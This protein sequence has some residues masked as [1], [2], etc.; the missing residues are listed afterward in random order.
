MLGDDDVT[1]AIPE[2]LGPARP[3]EEGDPVLGA[4]G[5]ALG[6]REGGPER[7]GSGLGRQGV[8]GGIEAGSC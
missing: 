1:A 3:L 7:S 5:L 8:K 2:G 6:P 4:P